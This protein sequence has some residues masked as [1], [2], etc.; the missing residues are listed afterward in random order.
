[1]G[2]LTYLLSRDTLTTQRNDIL[3]PIVRPYAGAIGNTLISNQIMLTIPLLPPLH[4]FLEEK[5]VVQTERPVISPD[6]YP[7]EHVC[8]ALGRHVAVEFC[9]LIC[10]TICFCYL[11]LLFV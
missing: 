2:T 5:I 4:Q 10:Q 7:I 8:Y 11:I 9:Y 3:D 6:L 1:M